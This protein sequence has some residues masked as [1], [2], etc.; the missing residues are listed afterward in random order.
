MTVYLALSGTATPGGDY[1]PLDNPVVIPDGSSSL[2]LDVIPFHDLILEP[3]EDVDADR[4]GQ[5]ELQRRLART[6]LS[7]DI[8]D[9]GTSKVPGV[10]FC[11]A[12][13]AFPESQ[14]PGIAV[15]LSITSSAPVTVDYKVIGGT[16]PANR[17]SLP[18]GTLTIMPSNLVAF[19]PLQ[20]VN[21]TIVEPPQTIQSRPVQPDQRHARLHQSPHLHDSRRRLGV[22]E[23]HCDRAE[24]FG[25]RSGAGQFP[26]LAHRCRPTPASW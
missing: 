14:S 5:H 15:A 16:A 8:L 23:R 4:A 18:Q 3:T 10:G 19:I 9:D 6:P 12:T 26:H 13:S 22:G 11:F 25:N 21:D 20:I 1:L 7:V 2:T 17:Y 24:R